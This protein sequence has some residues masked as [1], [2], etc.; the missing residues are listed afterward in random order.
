MPATTNRKTLSR[1]RIGAAAL[2]ILD[3]DGLDGLTMRR[4]ADA[5]GVGTM[6]LYGHVRSKDE[7]L[8]TAVDAAFADP[9]ELPPSGDW[10][11]RTRALAHAAWQ[12]LNKHPVL[13]QVR[14]RRPILRPE[15]LQ[16][17]EAGMAILRELGCG[18][19][20]AAQLF[21]LLFTYTVGFVGLSPEATQHAARREAAVAL[22]GLPEDAFPNLTATRAEFAEAMA[23]V[24]AFALGLECILDGIAARAAALSSRSP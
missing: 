23:G 9:L 22:A 7:L 20:E 24:G 3:S 11:S 2:E 12:R 17:G 4:L 15:A 10:R 6:T 5:L 16:F 13:V 8:E 19:R 21:R 18:D 14:L 1:Q